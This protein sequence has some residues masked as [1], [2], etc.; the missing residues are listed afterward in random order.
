MKQIFLAL[1]LV[2]LIF[3]TSCIRKPRGGRHPK[4][5]N[6][7]IENV[8]PEIVSELSQDYFTLE[9]GGPAISGEIKN[10]NLWLTF[11]E[12][13]ILPVG[14]TDDNSYRLPLGPIKV[15]GLKGAPKNFIIADIGQDYN[16]ILCV[17][18]DQGKVQMLSLWNSVV[19]GDVEA[20]EIP[21]NRIVGFK[22]G[23]GGPWEDEDGTVFYDYTTIYG[24]DGRG[25]EYEIPLY[26]F[27]NDLEYVTRVQGTDVVYQLY[28]GDDWKMRYVVGYYL[29]EKVEEWQG[30]FWL[31]NEDWDEM[32]FRYGYELTT[33]ME[34]TGEGINTTEVNRT[35][36]FDMQ[37]SDFDSRTHVIT[38]IEGVD[39][40]NKGMNV[41]VPFNP[42]SAYGG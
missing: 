10:D 42:S 38:P 18:T 7:P 5:K 19:T 8:K 26:N 31:I 2:I 4:V 24:V 30:R 25:N 32:V 20:T 17:L 39:F 29:S 40:A 34:Y 36:V 13:Q 27:D 14:I 6:E 9:E 23:P 35:G 1:S 15:E 11:N 22:D 33:R 12:D 16:P 28:L 3:S 21:M 41:S 37:Y